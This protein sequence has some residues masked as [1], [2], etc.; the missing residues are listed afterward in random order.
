[1]SNLL[2]S[3]G[4]TRDTKIDIERLG[5]L[6][7]MSTTVMETGYL[8]DYPRVPLVD[9]I[10]VGAT[11]GADAAPAVKPMVS[12]VTFIA[13]S[14]KRCYPISEDHSRF[15]AAAVTSSAAVTATG[16]GP[17]DIDMLV[18]GP[19]TTV[20]T[21]MPVESAKVMVRKVVATLRF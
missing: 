7:A 2:F 12:P 19:D 5:P 11:D 16:V 8:C 3:G 13:T 20:A 9:I 1:M 17:G 14:H 18:R 15:S 21:D 4:E 6:G 10:N